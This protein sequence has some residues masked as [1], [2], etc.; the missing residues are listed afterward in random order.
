[1]GKFAE[2]AG[3]KNGRDW[4]RGWLGM[5]S[6]LPSTDRLLNTKAAGDLQ[7]YEEV[8]QDPQVK[9]CL[10]QRFRGLISH[11]WEVLPGGDQAIDKTAAEMVHAQLLTLR[12]DDIVEKM[13]WGTFY[14]YSVAEVL[15]E[16]Q[17]DLVGIQDIRVRNRRRFHFDVDQQP[18]LKTFDSPFGEALP[19][20]KF[21]HFRCGAADDDEPYGRGLAHWLYWLV[22]F[23]KVDLRWWVRYL[24]LYAQPT[25]VGKYPAGSDQKAKDVL[26]QALGSFG[27]DDQIMIPEGMLVELLEAGRAGTADYDTLHGKL[28]EAIAKVILSQTMTT[29]NGSSMS[30]AQVHQDV[31]ETIIEA[32][33]DLIATSFN[34]SVIPWLIA[35]NYPGQKVATPKF[36]YKIENAPDLVALV[37]RDAKIAALGFPPT[38]EYVASTY[39]DGFQRGD[40]DNLTA[41]LPDG[42]IS[43][44]ASLIGQALTGTWEVDLL[45]SVMDM[46]YPA[47]AP[48]QKEAF[49]AAYKKALATA[50]AEQKK[51]EAAAT[52]APPEDLNALFA[53]APSPARLGDRFAA[54]EPFRPW[55]EQLQTLLTNST[56]LAEF[57]SAIDSAF[58]DL[59]EAE[60]QSLMTDAITAASLG[61][62]SNSEDNQ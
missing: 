3:I 10:Q 39:G 26:W 13:L 54:T 55:F 20:R 12:W 43:S 17:G 58:P 2:I 36:S 46:S 22:F 16:N 61:G 19:D 28:D 21:W 60:F 56:D 23:K 8:A 33:A 31:S 40:A 34:T 41:Q 30:Q 48:E 57:G 53:A 49:L 37:D 47:I 18:R 7:F 14:G 9:S 44:L 59:G 27:V 11:N 51:A 5:D 50:A 38:A 15:W 42:Q 32:D 35:Y 25:R 29:D 62:Y 52:A 6:Y 4:T 1:M 24:E 45:R